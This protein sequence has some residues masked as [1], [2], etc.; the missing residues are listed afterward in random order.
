MKKDCVYMNKCYRHGSALELT[1]ENLLCNDGEWEKDLDQPEDRKT[2]APG[3][4]MSDIT[5]SWLEHHS[6]PAGFGEHRFRA[7]HKRKR[8]VKPTGAEG[9]A[10]V[11]YPEFEA[12]QPERR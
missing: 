1:G 7:D 8:R 10:L 2:K 6:H 4:D 3:K 9:E 5:E 11:R 12:L